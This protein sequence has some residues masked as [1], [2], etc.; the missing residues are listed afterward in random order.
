MPAD[1]S[2]SC[3]S[4]SEVMK[5]LKSTY[6]NFSDEEINKLYTGMI[7]VGKEEQLGGGKG[8]IY[9]RG[10]VK[11]KTLHYY[12][13]IT[14]VMLT[15]LA[16]LGFCFLSER[17]AE[18]ANHFVW[19]LTDIFDPRHYG[20][21]F[22]IIGK[23]SS[24]GLGFLDKVT[25]YLQ[26]FFKN[27]YEGG[28]T[29]TWVKN[30]FDIFCEVEEDKKT[31]AQ[32]KIEISE[33]VGGAVK[34]YL[35]DEGINYA[36][37]E[38]IEISNDT[39]VYDGK[40]ELKILVGDTVITISPKVIPAATMNSASAS[41]LPMNLETSSFKR[42]DV[43]AVLGDHYYGKVPG[44]YNYENPAWKTYFEEKG[45]KKIRMKTRKNINKKM[46][47]K[48]Q[49]VEND[50]KCHI[51]LTFSF[52]F[53]PCFIELVELLFRGLFIFMKCFLIF[54]LVVKFLINLFQ[55]SIGENF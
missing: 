13:G 27:P 26:E 5:I 39:V 2:S 24:L 54:V 50:K 30:I 6:P 32:A 44:N 15:S 23:I 9:Q 3:P 16:G 41:S 31:V 46:K 19:Y 14:V 49:R 10:G 28:F 34:E 42:D 36:A 4:P 38:P 17:K 48:R 25:S 37:P 40:K 1:S 43:D 55:I 8:K 11:C 7:E 21:F 22:D 53:P 47:K 35:K 33:V 29:I 52:I 12:Y 51:I 45:G 18:L 20:H